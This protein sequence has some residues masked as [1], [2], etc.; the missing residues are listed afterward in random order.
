MPNDDDS[1][2]IEVL[3]Y[4]IKMNMRDY[5]RNLVSKDILKVSEKETKDIFRKFEEE[6]ND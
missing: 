1:L 6:Q 2:I 3:Q 4:V 5:S